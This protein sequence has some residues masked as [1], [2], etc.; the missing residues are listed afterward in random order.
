[1]T[2]IF[3]DM[4]H[5]DMEDYVD[6]ILVKSKTRNDHLRV[7]KRVFDRLKQHQLRLNPQ[8]CAFGVSSGKLLG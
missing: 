3:H 6:D 4:L 1:M 5:V 8:K 2:A 7:L